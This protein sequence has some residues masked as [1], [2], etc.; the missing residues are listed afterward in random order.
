MKRSERK[1][2]REWGSPFERERQLRIKVA[3]AAYA[4]EIKDD[5]IISDTEYDRLAL[6]ID[7]RKSTGNSHMDKWFLDNF[8]PST[9]MWVRNHPNRKGLNRIYKMHKQWRRQ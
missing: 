9:G 6:E 1:M 3:V 8:D 2:K 5:P 7:V 4:Y